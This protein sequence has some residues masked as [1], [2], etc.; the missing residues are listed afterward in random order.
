MSVI[1]N[2]VRTSGSLRAFAQLRARGTGD[3]RAL[4][5]GFAA[6]VEGAHARC[7]Q[8]V[9]RHGMVICGIARG[10]GGTLRFVHATDIVRAAT[11]LA[12]NGSKLGLQNLVRCFTRKADTRTRFLA[13]LIIRAGGTLTNGRILVDVQVARTARE[14][15]ACGIALTT[16]TSHARN[17][18]ANGGGRPIF[19]SLHAR[20]VKH[21]A[22]GIF[23][24]AV[25]HLTRAGR[26]CSLETIGGSMP[27]R[28][29]GE[30]AALCIHFTTLVSGASASSANNSRFVRQIVITTVTYSSSATRILRAT[31]L[32]GAKDLSAL[33][34]VAGSQIV[35]RRTDITSR[36]RWILF[37][38]VSLCAILCFTCDGEG[39]RFQVQRLA[40]GE[41]TGASG[42]GETTREGITGHG[43]ALNHVLLRTV[44]HEG[45]ASDGVT[46]GEGNTT[47]TNGTHRPS[48][49]DRCGHA[50]F[51]G[52]ALSRAS[53]RIAHS[54]S[55]AAFAI[56]A[57]LGQTGQLRLA[58]LVHPLADAREGTTGTG[59]VTA[60]G[61]GAN[62]VFANQ[63]ICFRLGHQ[64]PG[65]VAIVAGTSRI[66]H[67]TLFL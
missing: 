23:I 21:T 4:G 19:Q 16:F 14:E 58:Q 5:I 56:H 39:R 49:L 61:I 51:G 22:S 32:G 36:A 52:M 25:R 65:Y 12:V 48:A 60:F 9:A 2:N 24:A 11:G 59:R 62:R 29:T 28:S 42:I 47:F 40:A 37:A 53:Q 45:R 17:G 1:A 7:A 64:S 10:K 34:R 31:I 63:E 27:A 50:G 41:F 26:T 20:T 3:G 13:T 57:S 44:V 8:G 67:T 15:A 66:A 46:F 30:D 35:Q 43:R 6:F 33:I 18:G 55:I 54:D 38:T